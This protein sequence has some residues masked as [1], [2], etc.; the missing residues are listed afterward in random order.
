MIDNWQID[1]ADKIL[2]EL[3]SKHPDNN[4]IKI[5]LAVTQNSLY[6]QNTALQ[7]LDSILDS[8]PKT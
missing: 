7:L 5:L 3:Y 1:K 4:D 8:N 6:K 2:N